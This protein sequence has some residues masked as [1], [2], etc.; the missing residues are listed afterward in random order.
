MISCGEK[1]DS[2][3]KKTPPAEI[4]TPEQM[5]EVLVDVLL[6]EGA[7]GTA[8]MKHHDIKYQA[9]HYYSYILKKHKMTNQ[10]FNENFNYY[11][12]DVDQMEKIINDVISELSEK[13]GMIRK[14]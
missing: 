8:E 11:A 6:T 5:K 10:Q 14:K 4:V 12:G 1:K 7:I 13:E 3:G 2:V 9:L